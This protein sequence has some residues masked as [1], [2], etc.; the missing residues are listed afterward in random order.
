MATT[1]SP[2]LGHLA[3]AARDRHAVAGFYE[4]L[5]DLQIV[6][7]T[8]NALIGDAVLLSGRP[9]EEDHEL[10]LLTNRPRAARPE[11]VGH[12]R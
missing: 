4:D 10:G 9:V 12:S 8:R 2:R 7:Q 6:R 3:R 5:L 11:A 1:A